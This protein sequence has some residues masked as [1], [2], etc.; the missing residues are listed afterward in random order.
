MI[1][2]WLMGSPKQTILLRITTQPE[3]I[4]NLLITRQRDLKVLGKD[5]VKFCSLGFVI[6]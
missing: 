5:I 4:Q 1:M 6:I 2:G 3:Y